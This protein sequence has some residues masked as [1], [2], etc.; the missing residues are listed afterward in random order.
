MSEHQPGQAPADPSTKV[1]VE[2]ELPDGVHAHL[3][4]GDMFNLT[5]AEAAASLLHPLALHQHRA[6]LERELVVEAPPGGERTVTVPIK[7][8]TV[9]ELLGPV[10]A[11]HG[12]PLPWLLRAILVSRMP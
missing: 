6:F 5:P 11:L 4:E 7:Q 8:R 1:F 10:A 12:A 9:D 2:V 3:A